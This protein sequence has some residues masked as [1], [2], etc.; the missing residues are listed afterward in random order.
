ML[1]IVYICSC[2]LGLSWLNTGKTAGFIV[3]NSL[4]DGFLNNITTV[5]GNNGYHLG[6]KPSCSFC[7]R[8]LPTW[9]WFGFRWSF[10]R[11]ESIQAHLF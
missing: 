6:L 5:G 11:I 9:L 3:M 7:K 8:H 2:G 4:S 1:M 10:A